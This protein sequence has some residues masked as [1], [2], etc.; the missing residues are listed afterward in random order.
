MIESRLITK[1]KEQIIVARGVANTLLLARI[2]LSV[3]SVFCKPVH[4][5]KK[6]VITH[7]AGCSTL[8]DQCRNLSGLIGKE[9]EVNA[10]RIPNKSK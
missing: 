6:V 3:T 8:M 1:D 5:P 4:I 2:Y 7:G 9:S 10:V